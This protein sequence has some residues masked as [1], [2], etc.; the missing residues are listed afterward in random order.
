MIE[1]VI[2]TI[3]DQFPFYFRKYFKRREYLVIAVCFV[4]FLFGLVYF[5]QVVH[6]F[7]LF[8]S[9]HAQH[10]WFRFRQASTFLP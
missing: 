7:N 9:L 6:S 5:T 8:E 10:P 3:E 2:T 4:T 1:V